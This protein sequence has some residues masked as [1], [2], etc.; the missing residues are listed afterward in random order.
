[1]GELEAEWELQ[2]QR[3]RRWTAIPY[4]SAVAVFDSMS[5]VQDDVLPGVFLQR[6]SIDHEYFKRCDHHRKFREFL[7]VDMHVGVANI[8]SFG[9]ASVIEHHGATIV[10]EIYIEIRSGIIEVWGE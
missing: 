1:M 7:I 6:G 8:V 9:F 10:I 3:R 2:R 4:Q 5:L